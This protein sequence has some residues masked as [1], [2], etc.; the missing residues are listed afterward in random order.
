MNPRLCYFSDNSILNLMCISYREIEQIKAI[1][2]DCFVGIKDIFIDYSENE[3]S[4][5][6]SSYTNYYDEEFH[7]TEKGLIKV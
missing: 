6:V 2:L 4:L 3:K 5:T 7:P 1:I